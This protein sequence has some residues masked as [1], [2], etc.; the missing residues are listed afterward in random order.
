M[1]ST[2]RRIRSPKLKSKREVYSH[3]IEVLQKKKTF[4]HNGV[5]CLCGVTP[6]IY[7]KKKGGTITDEQVETGR[8]E[9]DQ[10]NKQVFMSCGTGHFDNEQNRWVTG[11]QFFMDAEKIPFFPVRETPNVFDPQPLDVYDLKDSDLSKKHL[12]TLLRIGLKNQA[13]VFTTQ[14]RSELWF[15]WRGINVR[16]KDKQMFIRRVSGS[17]AEDYFKQSATHTS[18]S[19]EFNGNQHTHYGVMYEDTAGNEFVE[20][21]LKP[22]YPETAYII[23]MVT[24]GS[25]IPCEVPWCLVSPDAVFFIRSK[26]DPLAPAKVVLLELK[27][28]PSLIN[29]YANEKYSTGGSFPVTFLHKLQREDFVEMG[30]PECKNRDAP[31]PQLMC[32]GQMAIMKPSYFIQIMMNLAFLP[33][34]IDTAYLFS[35]T[36]ALSFCE[37]IKVTEGLK[38]YLKTTFTQTLKEGYSRYLDSCIADLMQQ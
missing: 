37:E 26:I 11:C 16:Y 7:K 8:I 12:M 3:L 38:H 15:R 35:Y 18:M 17:S 33:Y 10:I 22:L 29:T 32:N 20:N 9:F 27:T 14:Q 24:I 36:P 19:K 2:S 25:Y 28:Q 6:A 13:D 4:E 21:I 1:L 5:T 30:F 31:M 34:D 23:E